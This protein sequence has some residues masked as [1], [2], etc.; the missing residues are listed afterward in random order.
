MS[1]IHPRG[2]FM[3]VSLL[4]LNEDCAELAGLNAAAAAAN[5][6]TPSKA[7]AGSNLITQATPF[8]TQLVHRPSAL[9]LPGEGGAFQTSSPAAAA[10]AAAAVISPAVQA[11]VRKLLTTRRKS[12]SS[13]SDGDGADPTFVLTSE[14]LTKWL[15]EATAQVRMP[16]VLWILGWDAIQIAMLEMGLED[17]CQILLYIKTSTVLQSHFTILRP[18]ILQCPLFALRCPLCA[19]RC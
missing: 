7:P 2:A 11:L 5:Q 12:P 18:W 17:R 9:S 10:A 19:L 15:A 1:S 16:R 14:D 13:G 3:Q 8:S 4:R 6:R